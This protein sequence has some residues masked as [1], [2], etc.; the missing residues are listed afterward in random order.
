MAGQEELTDSEYQALAEVRFQ[1]RRFLHFSE[2]AARAAGIEPQQHQLLLAIRGL[3]RERE[4]TIG[5]LAE[6]LQLQ[7]HS[8]VELVDRLEQRGLVQRRRGELD[9]RQVLVELTPAGE[10]LLHELSLHHRN[11]LRSAGQS[12]V[13]AL[14]A[15]VLG[16]HS[17]PTTNGQSTTNG[18]PTTNGTV[19]PSQEAAAG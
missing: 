13:Q 15:L 2:Q 18:Q 5:T 7:H 16:R 6:R 10:H 9:R 1:I 4:A 3:P 8:T 14:S 11:E 17:Q 19:A 12:L